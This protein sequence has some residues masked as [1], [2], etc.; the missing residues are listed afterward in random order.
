MSSPVVGCQ[1]I[2]FMR[3][4]NEDDAENF[5]FLMIVQIMAAPATEA[6]MTMRIVTVVRVTLDDDEAL[7]AD[8]AVAEA[9]EASVVT[10]TFGSALDTRGVVEEAVVRGKADDEILRAADE[11]EE[12]E[13]VLE[14][15]LLVED[16]EVSPLTMLLSPKGSVAE[17]CKDAEKD[18]TPKSRHKFQQSTLTAAEA[19]EVTEVW[20]SVDVEVDGEAEADCEA[21]VNVAVAVGGALPA[22]MMP[23]RP[24]CET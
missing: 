8:E 14:T 17:G 11:D 6:A 9:S 23:P 21:L 2:G 13:E 16:L 15:E 20:V 18:Q 3:S 12:V 22:P 10:V 7:A 4:S 19:G 5:H 1:S 24:S